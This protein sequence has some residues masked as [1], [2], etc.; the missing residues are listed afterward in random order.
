MLLLD[1]AMTRPLMTL[2]FSYIIYVIVLCIYRL[3]LHPL[4]KFP[5]PVLPAVTFWYEFYHDF[6]CRGQFIFRIKDMHAKYGPIVRVTPAELHVNDPAF[7]PELMPSGKH[8]RD[9]YPRL[10][11]LFGFSQTAGATAD[12]HLHRTRRA[13]MSKMFS[14]EAV[15]KLEPTMRKTW[16]KLLVRLREFQETGEEIHLLP[17]FGAF[18]ND[19]ITEYAY[20]FNMNWTQAPQFNRVFFE[21]V[22]NGQMLSHWSSVTER[23]QARWV[24]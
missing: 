8:R 1:I 20:G 12:H 22:S 17:M 4:A 7:L 21:M 11:Q 3:T 2:A 18:T 13:A 19:V 14:K 16:E 9:K 23:S 24:S 6:F 15:R 5:G 10:T